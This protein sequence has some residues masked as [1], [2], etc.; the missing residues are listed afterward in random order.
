M[1]DTNDRSILN[2]IVFH[3]HPADPMAY[4]GVFISGDQDRLLSFPQS[5]P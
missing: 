1:D 4:I 5:W 2:V 3:F